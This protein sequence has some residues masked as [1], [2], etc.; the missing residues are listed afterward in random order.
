MLGFDIGSR[1]G[2]LLAALRPTR[3]K[4]TTIVTNARITRKKIIIVLFNEAL[5]SSIEGLF[6][7]LTLVLKTYQ[8]TQLLDILLT[9]DST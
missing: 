6:D 8:C 3:V 2:S 7:L 5:G 1:N 9:Q 4:I